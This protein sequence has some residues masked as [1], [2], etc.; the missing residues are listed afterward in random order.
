MKM[1][2]AQS[3]SPFDSSFQNT[4][5]V[6]IKLQRKHIAIDLALHFFKGTHLV[7]IV[8]TLSSFKPPPVNVCIVTN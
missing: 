4:L 8:E 6:L 3:A 2:S 5:V 7:I 1:V